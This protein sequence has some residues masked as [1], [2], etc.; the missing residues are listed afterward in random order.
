MVIVSLVIPRVWPT[1]TFPLALPCKIRFFFWSCARPTLSLVTYHTSNGFPHVDPRSTHRSSHVTPCDWCIFIN[2]CL[3][4]VTLRTPINPR[5]SGCS[6][7][8][9]RKVF[10]LIYHMFLTVSASKICHIPFGNAQRTFFWCDYLSDIGRGWHHPPH[11][12]CHDYPHGSHGRPPPKRFGS[13]DIP[14]PIKLAFFRVRTHR[15]Q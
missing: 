8:A 11:T 2:V 3:C 7:L 6:S 12:P 5:C 9:N 13:N 14:G 4:I 15:I 1:Y 10:P